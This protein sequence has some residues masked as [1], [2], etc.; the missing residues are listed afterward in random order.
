MSSTPE[1]SDTRRLRTPEAARYVGLA[2]ATLI[3][4]R[5][6]GG[7]PVYTKLGRAV[8]YERAMLDRWIA[9]HGTR[10]NTSDAPRADGE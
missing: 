4:K 7:G 1:T 10:R 9:D 2:P 8:I 6:Q 5:C 3:R